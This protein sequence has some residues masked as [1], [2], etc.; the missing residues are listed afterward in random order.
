MAVPKKKRYKQVVSMRRTLFNN[1]LLG[2]KNIE[3]TKFINFINFLSY[4]NNNIKCQFN[5]S[6]CGNYLNSLSNK[7]CISCL[8][9]NKVNF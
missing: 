3:I 6:N 9:Y 8:S 7:I 1:I 2:K 5:S 4:S